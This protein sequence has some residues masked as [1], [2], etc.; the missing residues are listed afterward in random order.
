MP[1]FE[2]MQAEEVLRQFLLK[3]FGTYQSCEIKVLKVTEFCWGKKKKRR[4]Q[5]KPVLGELALYMNSTDR[6]KELL[7]LKV[8]AL[9]KS[10]K[11]EIFQ[12]EHKD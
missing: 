4:C 2:E 9:C 12:K 5:N 6:G 7:G 10:S 3:H 8:F 1:S 11:K